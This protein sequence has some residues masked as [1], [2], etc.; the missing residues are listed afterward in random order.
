MKI[1]ISML[2]AVAILIGLSLWTENYLQNTTN[3]MVGQLH[4]IERS[5]KE[6]NWNTAEKELGNLKK[7]WK[8]SKNLWGILLDHQEIDQIDMALSR[9]NEMILLKDPVNLLPEMAALK[10]LVMHIP[11]K[12]SFRLENIL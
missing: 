11:I 5:I 2:I 10:L 9:V 6:N 1:I 4:S 3:E 7:S 8:S 12:E